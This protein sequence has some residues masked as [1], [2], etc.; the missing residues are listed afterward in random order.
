ML[1]GNETVNAQA[2]HKVCAQSLA[3]LKHAVKNGETF[4]IK[5]H[6]AENLIRVGQTAGLEAEFILLK[7]ASPDNLIGATRVLARLNV[8]QHEKYRHYIDELFNQ[9]KSGADRKTQLTALE[10]LGKLG[11]KEPLPEIK[12]LADTGTNGF[13]GMARW[14][15]SNSNKETD[16]NRLSELLLSKDETDYRY[17]AYALRFKPKVNALTIK[18]LGQCLQNLKQDDPARIYVL[19]SFFVHD[20]SPE[21]TP[22][23]TALLTYLT[24]ETG[25]R[26]ELAEALGLGG[27]KNDLQVLQK[28]LNDENTDVQVAAANAILRVM[29]CGD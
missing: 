19:S 8:H 9:F 16:E 5:V 26:Y 14:V 1:A 29:H 24:G 4:F 27:N 12:L 3:V 17:A 23:K 10:S 18:R 25:Q 11:F 21:K 13:K 6:A 20:Q 22:V 15:L 2:D 28:L 7:E